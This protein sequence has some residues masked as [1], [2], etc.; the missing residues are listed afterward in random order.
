M[1]GGGGGLLGRGVKRRVQLNRLESQ[2]AVNREVC[3]GTGRRVIFITERSSHSLFSLLEL[4]Q[5]LCRV[6]SLY[7]Q[8]S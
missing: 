3:L 1:T 6:S 7:L 2:A 8:T 4:G 5:R